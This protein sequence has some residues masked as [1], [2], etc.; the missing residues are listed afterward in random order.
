MVSMYALFVGLAPLETVLDAKTA[1]DMTVKE[2]DALLTVVSVEEV[3][4]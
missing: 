4:I 1:E 2:D 3:V